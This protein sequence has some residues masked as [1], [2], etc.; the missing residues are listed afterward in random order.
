VG[1]AV[2]ACQWPPPEQEEEEEE[3]EEENVTAIRGEGSGSATQ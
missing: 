2:G 1:V 3:E